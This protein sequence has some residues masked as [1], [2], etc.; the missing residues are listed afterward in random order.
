M[1][2]F[3]EP[4]H[5]E[6]LGCHGARG[7]RSRRDGPVTSLVGGTS[8]PALQFVVEGITVKASSATIFNIVSHRRD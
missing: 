5:H 1:Q 8:C 4:G 3:A 6:R 7:G 2:A